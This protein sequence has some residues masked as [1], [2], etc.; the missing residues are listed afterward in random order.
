[1]RRDV[2]RLA[3][4]SYD[5]L[6]I[7]GGVNGLASAWDAAQ[8]GLAVA[9]IDQG[10]FGGATSSAS[11]K[12]IHGGLRYL[13]HFDFS[14]MRS[15]IGERSTMLKMA[16]HLID[17]FPFLVPTYGHGMKG[18]E[19]MTVA[20]FLN[21][22]IGRDRNRDLLDPELHIPNGGMVSRARCLDLAPVVPQEGLNGAALF[23]DG[24]MHN[25][26][27]VN[28]AFA[29]SA[30]TA[31]AD[32][33]NYVK[34]TKLVVEEGDAR[35]CEATDVLTGEQF[36]IT[37]NVTLVVAGPWSDF[38]PRLL[39]EELAA[40]EIS[41]SAGIQIVAPMVTK[42]NM[43]LGVTSQYVDPDSKL[44]RGGRHWFTTP[45]RGKTLWGTTDKLYRG[46]PSEWRIREEDIQG[47]ID[48]LNNDMPDLNLQREDVSYAFGGLRPMD[49]DNANKGSQVSRRAE[50]VDHDSQGIGQLISVEGVKYTTCR[51]VAEKAV[52]LVFKKMGEEPPA[53]STSD[54][55]L[56]GG[57]FDTRSAL[58]EE[59]KLAVGASA[60]DALAEYL[61]RNYGSRYADI[62]NLGN[63]LGC[64]L[65]LIPGSE[66]IPEVAVTYAVQQESALT[67]EDVVMRRTDAG[68]LAYPGDAFLEKACGIMAELLAWDENRVVNEQAKVKA[69]YNYS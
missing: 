16:P 10:D 7:G 17:P 39:G 54:A 57:D 49:A 2:Q 24:R 51:M 63:D 62:V 46:D 40:K 48:D 19:A 32:L 41:K 18:R 34:A 60:G 56:Q 61:F 35:G 43:G 69:L 44:K 65:A 31:G 14:R 6:I 21:D 59:I 66:E 45:W 29:T 12:I 26:D 25:A 5:L 8:R 67:L 11:L 3:A 38:I 52:D 33:A 15:S 4:N 50:M 47:F 37:A 9:L 13:Q 53:C 42:E 55:C 20:M 58:R 22:L 30:D 1:M 64:G 27:R 36:S 28:L 68:T 23:Y